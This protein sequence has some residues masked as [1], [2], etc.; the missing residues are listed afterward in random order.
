MVNSWPVTV[1]R[2]NTEPMIG[3]EVAHYRV[4][5]EIGKGA[6]GVVYEAEDTRLGR[7]VALK[8]LTE[9]SGDPHA[10]QRFQREARAAS[11]LNHPHI[12][13][14]HDIGEY[15]G[16]PFIVMERLGGQPLKALMGQ[17]PIAVPELLNLAIQIASALEATHAKGIVHRDIKPANIFV[18]SGGSAKMVDFGLAKVVD[19]G[20]AHLE[21]TVVDDAETA[22]EVEPPADDD[23]VTVSGTMV[24]TMA[25]MSPE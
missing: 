8:F 7:K 25:Y 24:G 11:A 1:P 17:K 18:T 12:C 22:E 6:M 3:K 16:A 2:V 21:Q 13:T 19:A 4:L 5:A 23:A 20:Q 10:L 15:E 9:V 14:I